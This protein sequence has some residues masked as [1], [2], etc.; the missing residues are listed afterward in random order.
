M[1]PVEPKREGGSGGATDRGMKLGRRA[2]L[3]AGDP[4]DPAAQGAKM[5]GEGASS[6][7]LGLGG[8]PGR[9]DRQGAQAEQK[10]RE[11]TGG[12]P[13]TSQEGAGDVPGPMKEPAI[14]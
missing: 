10:K 14:T 8:R 4:P 5:D 13:K 9:V 11:G 12:K 6:L 1:A 2:K 7:N 3:I